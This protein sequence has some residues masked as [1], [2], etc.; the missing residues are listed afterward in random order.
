MKFR[1]FSQILLNFNKKQ[2][3]VWYIMNKFILTDVFC[4]EAMLDFV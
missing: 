4:R 2:T 1:C 3:S